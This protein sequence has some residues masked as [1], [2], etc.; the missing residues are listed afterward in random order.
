MKNKFA[1]ASTVTATKTTQGVEKNRTYK[2]VDVGFQFI[3]GSGQRLVAN[4]RDENGHTFPVV[5]PHF[6][7]TVNN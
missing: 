7:F 3:N 2:L 4:V 1:A 5:D 6:V